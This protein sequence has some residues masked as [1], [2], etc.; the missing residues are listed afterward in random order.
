MT[1]IIV[2]V[3]GSQASRAALRWAVAHAA[4]RY[5]G[6]RAV[7][8]WDAPAVGPED[9]ERML[10]YPAELEAQARRELDVVVDAVIAA[11]PSTAAPN[12]ERVVRRGSAAE[13]LLE[14]AA[15][16]DLLVLGAQGLDAADRSTLG[17]VSLEVLTRAT[18]PVVVVPSLS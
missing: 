15:D 3:D 17:R 16:A 11:A 6:V 14:D 4:G 7:H 10:T 2:G 8:A 5:A 9:R 13:C 1:Q 12:I 18:C